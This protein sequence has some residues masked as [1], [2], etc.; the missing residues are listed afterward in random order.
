MKKVLIALLVIL[1]LVP[2]AASAYTVKYEY[3]I[4]T[5]RGGIAYPMLDMAE[6]NDFLFN[7]GFSFRKGRD[8]EISVGGGVT[9]AMMPYKNEEAPEPF[10]ATMIMGE[11]VYSP[12]LPDFFLW[13]YLKG[14]VGLFLVNVTKQGPDNPISVTDTVFGFGLGGGVNYPITNEFAATIEVLYHQASVAGGTG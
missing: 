4:V 5:A 12:Y 10:T 9:Y 6:T 11:V 13:P 14:A 7:A 3:W 2:A 1:F 8:T